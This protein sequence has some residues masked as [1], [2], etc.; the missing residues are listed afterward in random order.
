MGS[1]KKKEY[2]FWG[3]LFTQ[4]KVKGN[5]SIKDLWKYSTFLIP[6]LAHPKDAAHN[7]KAVN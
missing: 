7:S 6:N 1:I 4:V 5:L 3:Y 2:R